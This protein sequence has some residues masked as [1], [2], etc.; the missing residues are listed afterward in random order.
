MFRTLLA[1]HQGVHYFLLYERVYCVHLL[2][3][4]VENGTD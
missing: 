2:D 1:H 4:I 3:E